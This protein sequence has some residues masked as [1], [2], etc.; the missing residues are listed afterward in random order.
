MK[1]SVAFSVVF[2][3]ASSVCRGEDKPETV[4]ISLDQIWANNMPGTRDIRDLEPEQRQVNLRQLPPDEQLKVK[5][6]S[7]WGPIALSLTETSMSWPRE[8]QR[9]KAGFA[10]LG[11]GLDALHDAYDVLAGG[12]D[13]QRSFTPNDEISIVFFSYECG[14]LVEIQSVER[15]GNNIEIHYR[16][17]RPINKILAAHL[18]LIPLGQ[19]PAGE[20]RVETIQSPMGQQQLDGS[21]TSLKP[22]PRYVKHDADLGRR[23]VSGPF[24]FKVEG[25]QSM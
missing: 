3:V 11:S 17:V 24:S 12:A 19:L 22:D 1:A 8:G 5:S 23:F 16:L 15:H 13:P 25:E 18:A 2:L 4:T 20:Y 6:K 21:Y 7:L 10:V 9:A 14:S